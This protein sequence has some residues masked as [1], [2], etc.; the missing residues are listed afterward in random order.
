M[1]QS[2][3]ETG[4][5]LGRSSET[6]TLT[7]RGLSPFPNDLPS[8]NI[9]MDYCVHQTFDVEYT[10]NTEECLHGSNL[11]RLPSLHCH[12]CRITAPC[13]VSDVKGHL[14]GTC[15]DKE[16]CRVEVVNTP[17]LSVKTQLLSLLSGSSRRSGRQVS[18]MSALKVPEELKAPDVQ[19][20]V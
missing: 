6:Y 17:V 3:R 1:N 19:Q 12:V 13:G 4:V 16:V 2:F 5:P 18:D 10:K 8:I 20:G 11:C 15:M 14:K 7:D 9:P